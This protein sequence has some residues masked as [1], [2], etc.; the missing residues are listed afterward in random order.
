M[1][2]KLR[3]LYLVLVLLCVPICHLKA[4][5]ADFDLHQRV[6]LAVHRPYSLETDSKGNVYLQSMAGTITK[7]TPSGKIVH[8][9]KLNGIS[10]SFLKQSLYHLYI[11]SKDHLYIINHSQGTISKFSPEGNLFFTFGSKGEGPGQFVFLARIAVNSLG[12]IFASDMENHY[13]DNK[14]KRIHKFDAQGNFIKTFTITGADGKLAAPLSLAVDGRDLL[15]VAGDSHKSI[16]QINSEGEVLKEI[17]TGE[18]AASG[19]LACDRKTNQ[20]YLSQYTAQADGVK[21]FN[22]DGQYEKTIETVAQGLVSSTPYPIAITPE[23]NLLAVDVRHYG[24]ST[25]FSYNKA[26]QVV[27]KWGRA[28]SA[29]DAALDDQGNFYLL[30]KAGKLTKFTPKGDALWEVS[31]LISSK[32]LALDLKSNIYVICSQDSLSGRNGI[33]KLDPTGKRLAFFTNLSGSN[34]QVIPQGIYVDPFGN[35]FVTDLQSGAVLKLDAQGKRVA[36]IGTMGPEPGKLWFPSAVMVD[37]NGLVLVL[38]YFGSRVQQFTQGGKFIRHFGAHNDNDNFKYASSDLALDNKGNIYTTSTLHKYGLSSENENRLRVFDAKGT[39]LQEN[40][41]S[42]LHYLAFDSRGASLATVSTEADVFSL[43]RSKNYSAPLSVITGRVFNERNKNCTMDP[44]ETGIAGLVMEATPGPYYAHT[45]E[46]GRYSFAVDSGSYKIRVVPALILGATMTV[47]CPPSKLPVYVSGDTSVVEAPDIAYKILYN[48]YLTISVS[49]DRRRRCFRNT[50]TVSYSNLGYAAAPDAKVTVQLPEFVHFI[51]ASVP[52]TKD[53]IGNYV[54]EVGTLAALHKGTITITDS[55]SCA[56]PTIR[57]LTVCTKAWISP[58]NPEDKAV[59]WNR[60]NIV[61]NGEDPVD[62]QVR[63]V[64]TNVGSGDMTDSLSF[65]LIQ[66]AELSMVG[67]YRLAAGDSLA[68]K[69]APLGRALRL[70]ADQPPGHPIKKSASANLEIRSLNDGLPSP[71]MNALPPDDAEQE[72][73]M[74][75]LPIIDSY[76]PNDKQVIPVGLT[77]EKYTPTSTPLRYT[78]RFQ[79]T[80]TDVAYRVVVVDTLSA[81][82]NISTLRMGTASHPYR[83]TVSGKERPVLTFIFDNIMLPDS[84]KDLAGSNGLI[85]FSI[86][87]KT[88][89][90]EKQLI[91]NFADIFFDYNEPV[92][93]NTTTNRIYDL[94]LVPNPEKQLQ[95]KDALV[96]PSITA[97]VPSAGKYGAVVVISGTNF[98]A[99]NSLN[100]VYFNGKPAQ[101]LE[102]TSTGIK[103]QV[104]LGAFTGKI[105]VSH[106]DGSTTTFDDF[107]VY[108][109]PVI[110]GLSVKEGVV[111]IEVTIQGE[112]L[113]PD[114]LESI[115]LGTVPC[116][117]KRYANNGVIV[118]IPVGAVS[119]VFTVYSKGGTAQSGQFRVWHMP[120]ITGFDKMR[121]RVGGDVALQGENFAPE[122]GLNQVYFGEKVA[123]V[124][125]AREQQVVVQ[126]P[127]GA[128]T[129]NVTISTPGG[130][131]SKSFEVIPG[132]VLT[133]ILPASASV[134]TVVELKGLNFSALGQPDTVS[135]GDVKAEVLSAT[136]TTLQVRVPRGAVSGKVTVAGV[137]GKSKADFTVLSLTP[138]ESIEVYPLPNQG[139]FTIDFI[140]ADFDVHTLQ[141][142]DKTGRIIYRQIIKGGKESRLDISLPRA[143]SG[144]YVILLQTSQGVVTKRVVI[145]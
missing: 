20:V 16:F 29:Q 4:Q 60:A 40:L 46:D 121:Q 96:S 107:T 100:K 95:V 56:D 61:I 135:F 71:A 129:G 57:G 54:F 72:I 44:G 80:G 50:T 103:V 141:M 130:S 120:A 45:D 43:Y 64:V 85:Q 3:F 86:R 134:G 142:L 10:E 92:R 28:H 108:Q 113:R 84:S 62:G 27:R 136:A 104:P 74:D 115:T 7:M 70:E 110:T 132:P 94:P 69:F 68:L 93:T 22:A 55:V 63:F 106:V 139:R 67:R 23:G 124:L 138:Q 143:P 9:F 76:D 114:L 2:K 87:P 123:K 21:V 15:Y 128:V 118:A 26:G 133:A 88:T 35:M 39:L 126:V 58:A 127:S 137:G 119:G 97:Y 32:G 144:I 38:D 25:L 78:V 99:Q 75:C 41:S 8:D 17:K 90:S 33:L 14:S 102:A 140:K 77:S 31:S 5:L 111:G 47:S 19:F 1:V 98:L 66:D 36:S 48:P 109:P 65:R 131:S 82:L 42:P 125:S 52:F 11:D 37:K 122:A 101:V 49:S 116:Q 34:E 13:L 117:I 53:E 18:Q 12:E 6:G 91:E 73:A 81:D 83:L 59:D 89:L 105:K 79:N 24:N 30:D 112:N 51:S 145:Q